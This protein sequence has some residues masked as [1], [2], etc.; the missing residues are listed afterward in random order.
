MNYSKYIFNDQLI[1]PITG[2]SC[3]RITKQN[4][5]KFGFE[6]IEELKINL[7]NFPL[8]CDEYYSKVKLSASKGNA[9][10][11]SLT[12]QKK[13]LK[14]KK[15]Q[16]KYYADPNFCEKCNNVIQFK[17]RTNRFCSR[18]CANSHIVSQDHKEKTSITL[19]KKEKLCKVFFNTC[20]ECNKPFSTKYKRQLFC[21]TECQQ[22][23]PIKTKSCKIC[24]NTISSKKLYCDNC[25]SNIRHY[26]SKC[27]FDFNV[28]DYPDEFNLD[29]VKKHGW[30]SPNGYKRKNKFVNLTGVSKD[31][32]YTISDGY[33]NGIDPKILSHPANCEIIIHNGPNGNNSKRSSSIT[34]SDLHLKIDVWNKKYNW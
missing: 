7:P 15:Q 9:V 18:S 12:L 34:L 6:T 19:T 11:V 32:L 10:M 1:S 16:E 33:I 17:K 31:H 28:F 27:K 2:Y 8:M 25:H 21:S 22:Y 4:I 26:R 20:K 3:K 23:K 13:S 14:T 30:F 5:S 24:T 29:L